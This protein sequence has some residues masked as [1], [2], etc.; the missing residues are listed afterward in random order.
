MSNLNRPKTMHELSIE[1][2]KEKAAERVRAAAPELLAALKD[3]LAQLEEWDELNQPDD[4]PEW[5][6]VTA[7]KAAIAKAEGR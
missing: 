1:Q 5:A 3:T 6:H 4:G 7:T 2:A